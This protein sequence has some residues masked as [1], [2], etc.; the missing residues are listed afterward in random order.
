M[1]TKSELHSQINILKI[2][3]NFEYHFLNLFIFFNLLII[4]IN[5]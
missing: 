1:E 4:Y 3:L 2:G 5:F